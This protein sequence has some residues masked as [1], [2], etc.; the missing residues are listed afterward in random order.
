MP[1]PQPPPPN[2][3]DDVFLSTFQD[4][5]NDYFRTSPADLNAHIAWQDS[6]RP[7]NSIRGIRL[8]PGSSITCE[9]CCMRS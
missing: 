2:Q 1:P 7:P 4:D 9:G 3:T 8:P 5:T 6:L